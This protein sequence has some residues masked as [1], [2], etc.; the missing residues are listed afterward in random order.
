MRVCKVGMMNERERVGD[1]RQ[2]Y[3]FAFSGSI[4]MGAVLLLS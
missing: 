4:H 1:G 2:G 3:N